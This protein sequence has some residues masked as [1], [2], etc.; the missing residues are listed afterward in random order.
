[1][2]YW[3]QLLERIVSIIKFLTSRGLAF[4]GSNDIIGSV[5]NG[6]YLG[7]LELLA[8]YDN[9][10]AEHIQRRANKGR[11]HVSYLLSTI[12]NK[13]IEL[14]GQEVRRH[15]VEEVKA[16]KYYSVSVDSTP[17]VA[18]TDLL[19]VIVRYVVQ[20][21]SIERF[22]RIRGHTGSEL[23]KVLLDFL[24]DSGIDIADCRGQPCD[25]ASEMSGKYN[26]MQAL[27][28]E[29]NN[30]A[31]YVPCCAHSLNL[32]GK[33]ALDYCTEAVLFFSAVQK[34]YVFF[35]ASTHRWK[36]LCDALEKSAA[37]TVKRLS[38]TRWSAHADAICALKK[39]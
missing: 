32:V 10:L 26:R 38:D 13:F 16:A 18:Y 4:R 39:G 12:C 15:I 9:F 5:H 6:N 17:D 23:A 7:I 19:T 21:N 33:C 8:E 34:I 29:K 28:K 36:I 30:L 11:G 24:D 25:N 37:P 35:S 3:Y 22:L 1:M 2:K 31:E 14:L 27:I 20:D